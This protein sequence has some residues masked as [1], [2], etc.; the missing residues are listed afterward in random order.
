MA[1]SSRCSHYQWLGHDVLNAPTLF[2]TSLNSGHGDA[3]ALCPL[4][5]ALGH[6]A[7]RQ[8][9]VSARVAVLLNLSCPAA[10]AGFV[11]GVVV[12]ALNRMFWRRAWTHILQES[13]EAIVTT[14]S[15]ADG[16]ATSTVV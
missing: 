8:V 14:P 5:D 1:L 2:E 6:S 12:G 16:D 13:L 9:V 4:C 10:V 3:G 11:T 7:N 15:V